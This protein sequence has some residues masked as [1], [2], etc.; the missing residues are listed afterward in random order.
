MKQT[1]SIPVFLV[2]ILYSSIALCYRERVKFKPVVRRSE[3]QDTDSIS[4]EPE[5]VINKDK[6]LKVL[7]A[8]K[9]KNHAHSLPTFLA[10]LETLNCPQR[11]TEDK[12][13]T[14]KCHLWV[15]F[16]DCSDS[17]YDLFV[18]WLAE[19]RPLFDTIIMLDTH[20]DKATRDKHVRNLI[21]KSLQ[22]THV[23]IIFYFQKELD[24]LYFSSNLKHR[25]LIFALERNFTHVF[26]S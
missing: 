7:L 21:L 24:P 26:V 14:N 13:V 25:A 1:V 5:S 16:D 2:L 9:I 10:T 22:F 18:T 11:T 8:I 17:S 12:E 4:V 20:N 23:L 15:V 6:I 3:H 19:T